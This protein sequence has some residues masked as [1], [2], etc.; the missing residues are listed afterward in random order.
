MNLLQRTAACAAIAAA[1]IPC[2]TEAAARFPL[3]WNVRNACDVP[4]EVE[5]SPEKLERLVGAPKGCGWQVV[6]TTAGGERALATETFAGKAPGTLR[7][8]FRVPDGTTALTCVSAGKAR[9]VGTATLDNLFAGALSP[10][11]AGRWKVPPSVTV[12]PIKGGL[13]FRNVRGNPFVSYT[14][15][16]P[17]G[18]A[19]KSVVQEID[20]TSH[21]RLAWG[22]KLYVTQ[23]DGDGNALPDQVADL[24]WTSHMRPR[25]KFTRYR[26]EGH[27][28]PLAKRLRLEIELRCGSSKYDEYGMPNS[29]PELTRPDLDLTHVA[30]RPAAELPFPKWNDAF[31]APG[32]SGRPGDAALTLGGEDERAMFYQLI[33]RGGW[34]D[35]FQYRTEESRYFPAGDGTVEAW[36]RPD[37]AALGKSAANRAVVL[38][39]AYQGYRA[40]QRLNG[41]GVMLGLSYVPAT[42]TFRLKM[43]DW[44]GH[45]YSA[46]SGAVEFPGGEWTHVALAWACR[47]AADVYVNGRR[48]MT[49]AIPDYKAIPIADTSIENVN[50]LW[51]MEFFL[52]ASHFVARDQNGFGSRPD[53]PVFTGAADELRVSTG[54]RYSGDFTPSDDFAPDAATRALFKFDRAFDGVSA[55]GLGFIPASIH[56]KTDRVEHR[57]AGGWYWAKD[58]LP[59][60]D[61]R[62]V[63]DICN[64]PVMPSPAEYREARVT[65]T[66]SRMAKDGDSIAF[67]AAERAYPEYV[68]YSNRDGREQ[69]AYPIL[70]GRGRLDPRSFGDMGD[71]MGIGS[72]AD[73]EKANRVFQ[74]VIGASDYFMCHNLFFRPLSDT[75]NYA[76]YE[77]MVML[78]SYCGFECGPLNNMAANMFATVAN[79]PSSQT[80]GY[81]HSFEQVFFDGKNHIYDLSS[82]KF[83]PAMDNES[84]AY[85][86]EGGDQPGIFN[87][88]GGNPDHFIRKGTRGHW[89]QSPSYQEKFGVVLN[90]GET[91]RVHYANDG[92]YNN[93]MF[94]PGRT[95]TVQDELDYGELCGAKDPKKRG[96]TCR[97]DRVFPQHSSG[98]LTFAGRPSAENP[99]FTNIAP[100]SFCYRVRSPNPVVWAEYSAELAD[101]GTAEL[102]VSTDGGGTFSA[103]PRDENGVAALEYRVKAR[104]EYLVR[105]KAPMGAVARFTARTQ[106]MVNPRTYPA[107]VRGG[108]NEFTYRAAKGPA[109]KVT[110]AWREPAK[111]IVVAGAALSGAIPGFERS[112]FLLDPKG[113]A[114]LA[115]SGASAAATARTCGR[116]RATLEGGRLTVSADP[117]AR[118]AVKRGVDLPVK[119]DP[120][121][122]F[123]WAEI[124]DG[125][126]V[127]RL[128]FIVA[129]NA[130][131][132]TAGAAAALGSDAALKG[133]DETSAQA[134]FVLKGN[135]SRVRFPYAKLPAGRYAVFALARFPSDA[136]GE[137]TH[138]S[139]VSKENVIV[140]HDPADGRKTCV[141][142]SPNNGGFEFLEV[143]FGRPGGLAQWKWDTSMVPPPVQS[144]FYSWAFQLHDFGETDHLDLALSAKRLFGAELAAILVVE[145]PDL[146][147]RLDM[148]RFLCGLN[149]DPMSV[150]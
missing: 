117:S 15:D 5:V 97:R 129:P 136:M 72:L 14:V 112:L 108:R 76:C 90:P 57:L 12:T 8:R 25:D 79:C 96:L 101:G 74:Y 29:D 56:A 34:T 80:G 125:D 82:L 140:M 123:A 11:N 48:A 22:G 70:V 147:F 43:Q 124:V 110:V 23:L 118:P 46:T 145:N 111:E 73:R 107:W 95:K 133:P 143:M 49:L 109:A 102:E 64:F 134:R 31:F 84:S 10:G 119:A 38:F 122:Y 16:V 98:V 69:V 67:D 2:A 39:Q 105:V 36:F 6:A 66:L 113:K 146:E 116:I 83:F 135:D 130:R 37:W 50:D 141:V 32:V 114:E 65:K 149:A 78:N 7:L 100:G 85:L 44:E 89:A 28:H 94:Y 121:T 127:K 26:D 53:L 128:T 132:V 115:V 92:Q 13:N 27:I 126:A 18:L 3:E 30:V 33:P 138:P 59:G 54:R 103:L 144:S 51:A 35:S 75:P 91:Y 19:G 87:R 142:A 88:T 24:R 55:G 42:K 86:K 150:R 1:S 17:E 63:L 58:L 139:Y 9:M 71:S 120:S 81:G 137:G 68:E 62:K 40:A 131:L 52:G 4:Y 148:R 77:A 99:A 61:Y 60:H 106:G 45:A 21:T 93:M 41:K 20:L 47:G 104:H